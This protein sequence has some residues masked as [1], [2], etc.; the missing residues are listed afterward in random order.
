MP[1]TNVSVTRWVQAFTLFLPNTLHTVPP[2][3]KP[4]LP[5]R[6]RDA[7]LLQW[8]HTG[9]ATSSR[10]RLGWGW[11]WSFWNCGEA[12]PEP[13]TPV[14]KK[15]IWGSGGS[16]ETPGPLLTHPHTVHMACSECLPTRLSP[17]A[18]RTCFSQTPVWHATSSCP[19]V[20]KQGWFWQTQVRSLL[21]FPP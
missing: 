15:E 8:A 5:A 2:A 4:R 16:L 9:E 6:L 21:R 11:C 19:W 1:D 18:E 13:V 17:L 10:R 14:R 3:N 12:E 20:C 7:R